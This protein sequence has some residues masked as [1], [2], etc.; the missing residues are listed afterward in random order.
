M[1]KAPLKK[2]TILP[3]KS[4]HI[5]VTK[6]LLYEVRNELKSDI[7][8][9][10]HKMVG[11]DKKIDAVV[12]RVDLI[13]AKLDGKFAEVD[14]RFAQIDARFEQIDARFDTLESKLDGFMHSIKVLVEDQKANNV[15]VLDGYQQ[16][17]ARQ[18]RLEARVFKLE[19]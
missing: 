5:P 16:L 17:F 14:A 18:D 2:K 11:L 4:K 7:S 10:G 13:D 3:L 1:K 6:E 8:V 9:L 15:Y 12:A 19:Q